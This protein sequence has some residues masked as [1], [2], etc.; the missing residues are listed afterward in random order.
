MPAVSIPGRGLRRAI[1]ALLA[2]AT[3][4]A[5]CA[6]PG[7][8]GPTSALPTQTSSATA[9]AKSAATATAQPPA[10]ATTDGPPAAT[11]E[12]EGGEPVV[13][14]LGPY[15]WGETGTATG[16]LRGAPITIGVGEELVLGLDPALPIDSWT[17]RYVPYAADSPAD[18]IPLGEGSDAPRFAGPPAGAWTVE[19]SLVFAADLGEA[20]YAWA[21]QVE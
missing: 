11:L 9:S 14:Q 8:S 15:T 6:S 12:V 3:V 17:A 5:A 2:L 20:R 18:A 1:V 16:W 13:G 4:S 7:A 10:S 21:V 19:V